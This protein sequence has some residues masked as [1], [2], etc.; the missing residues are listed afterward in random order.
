MRA[1]QQANI[2]CFVFSLLLFH[3]I[4]PN[5]FAVVSYGELIDKITILMIKTERISNQEKLK[6]INTELALLQKTYDNCITPCNLIIELQTKLK[7]INE[8]LWDIEDAIRIKEHKKEF[9]E[10]F[11]QLARNVYITN[12]LRCKI[13]KQIDVLLGSY[14]TEEKSYADIF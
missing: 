3:C 9:D 8:K 11:I 5:A 12:D 13:K 7:I 4:H 10:E 6:N 1:L 2:I 14:L